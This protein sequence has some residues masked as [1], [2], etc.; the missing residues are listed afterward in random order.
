[1]SYNN[2]C[3]SRSGFVQGA[4]HNRFTLSIQSWGGL[5]QK[6]NIRISNESSGD[7]YSLFLTSG[8]LSPTLANQGV[9]FLKKIRII[10]SHFRELSRQNAIIGIGP[11]G[12][13][14]QGYQKP[15]RIVQYY[16]SMMAYYIEVNRSGFFTNCTRFWQCCKKKR[17]KKTVLKYL[18]YSPCILH[19]NLHNIGPYRK[20]L[21]MSNL[22]LYK[23]L[24][25]PCQN[26]DTLSKQCDII[27]SMTNLCQNLWQNYTRLWYFIKTMPNYDTLPKLC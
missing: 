19:N 14:L 7:G 6:Q 4:L 18:Q 20:A 5:I 25:K 22:W 1:M 8:E 9:I 23:T 11:I 3:S 26:Y 13:G 24:T 27:P 10:V 21:T 17:E 15:V 2:C 12:L 16:K